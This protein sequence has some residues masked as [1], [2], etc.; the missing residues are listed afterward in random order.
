M[1][2]LKQV[3]PLKQVS[4][5][6]SGM[7]QLVPVYDAGHIQVYNPLPR[8]RQVPLFRPK[9]ERNSLVKNG[10]FVYLHGFEEHTS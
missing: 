10:Y 4:V 6:Q 3:P 1:F 5:A 8:F 9:E 7:L 2:W